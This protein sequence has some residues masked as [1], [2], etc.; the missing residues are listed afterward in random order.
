[1]IE[2][3]TDHPDLRTLPFGLKRYRPGVFEQMHACGSGIVTASQVPALFGE[4]RFAG[5]FA[6]LAHIKGLSPLESFGNEALM[7]RGQRLEKV[8]C[9]MV[10]E[11]KGWVVNQVKAW[12][13]HERIEKLAASPDAV[14]WREE[15]PGEGNIIS[16]PGIGEIK[17]VADLVWSQRWQEGPPLDVELQHQTQFACTGAS[18]GFIAA[19]VVGTFRWDLIVYETKSRPD[20]IAIIEAEVE[21]ALAA[22]DAGDLGAPD[23]HEASIRAAQRLWA[24]D[25]DKVL[26]LNDEAWD[27][28]L[29]AWIEARETRLAAQKIEDEKKA[30]FAAVALDAGLIR[31]PGGGTVTIKNVMRKAYQVAASE[32]RRLTPKPAKDQ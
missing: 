24:P 14:A 13:A 25:P 21:A 1:M 4:S 23:E 22:L 30:K 16:P 15:D 32:S 29:S 18:W 17:V 19:L 10:A 12:K 8:A 28:D 26:S 2:A 6:T 20:V 11:E 7:A 5:R 3:S 9:E 27:A 31:C